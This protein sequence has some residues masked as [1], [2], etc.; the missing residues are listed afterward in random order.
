M[1]IK[2]LFKTM[3]HVAANGAIGS[4]L[5]AVAFLGRN[6]TNIN[7]YHAAALGATGFAL[8]SITNIALRNFPLVGEKINNALGKPIEGRVGRVFNISLSTAA[9]AGLLLLPQVAHLRNGALYIAGAAAGIAALKELALA[10]V[11]YVN[12]KRAK[13]EEE[14]EENPLI[15]Q[16]NSNPPT[17]ENTPPHSEDENT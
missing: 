17:E 11:R 5:G 12:S 4:S 14:E 16:N 10:T 3:G 6:I 15:Q 13:S 9:T 7:P 1:E 8:G 2:Q